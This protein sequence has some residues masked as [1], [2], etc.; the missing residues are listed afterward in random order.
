MD[1]LSEN[2]QTELLEEIDPLHE[3]EFLDSDKSEEIVE[4]Y[5]DKM[6]KR[7]KKYLNYI[8]R[9]FNVVVTDYLPSFVLGMTDCKGMIWMKRLYGYL[10]E[11]V[12]KHEIIH[13]LFP[14]LNEAR[15]EM[16][17]NAGYVKDLSSFNL[18]HSR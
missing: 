3:S 16:L 1:Y 5:M 17:N 7:L 6:K 9:T 2:Y 10:K 4:N 14:Y 13:N 18:I 8:K 12:L 11:H 15:V